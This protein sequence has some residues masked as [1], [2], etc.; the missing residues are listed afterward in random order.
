MSQDLQSSSLV[1]ACLISHFHL[2]AYTS[3][4]LHL[5]A[6]LRFIAFMT[7]IP[8]DLRSDSILLFLAYHSLVSYMGL[9]F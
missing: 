7:G 1:I 5:R 6:P 3:M 4:S 2:Q 9:L 8:A